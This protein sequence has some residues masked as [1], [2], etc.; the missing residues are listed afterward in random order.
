[1]LFP[2]AGARLR[3]S[4]CFKQFR[5]ARTQLHKGATVIFCDSALLPEIFAFKE[6]SSAIALFLLNKRDKS[7]VIKIGGITNV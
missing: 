7:V 5:A 3:R 1:M 6:F 2:T 4:I